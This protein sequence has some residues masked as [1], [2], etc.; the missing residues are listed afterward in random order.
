[1]NSLTLSMLLAAAAAVA[2]AIGAIFFG[3]QRSA[4]SRH[5]LKGMLVKRMALFKALAGSGTHEGIERPDRRVE[6]TVS[7]EEFLQQYQ[8]GG[9]VV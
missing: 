7:Q 8:P 5:G 9:F 6:T 3:Q 4:P 2:M 1:M